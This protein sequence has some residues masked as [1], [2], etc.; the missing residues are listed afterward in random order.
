LG[1][2]APLFYAQ[3]AEI[4]GPPK[5]LQDG[6]HFDVPLRHD[7]R[8]LFCK[9]WNFAGRAELLAP[10]AKVDVLFQIQDDAFSRKRGYGSWCISLK[11]VRACTA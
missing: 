5:A 8:L 4:A 3:A 11:D 10:G 7:G 6:K 1:N 2:P 9:A